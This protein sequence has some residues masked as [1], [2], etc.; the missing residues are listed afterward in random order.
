MSFAASSGAGGA[1]GGGATSLLAGVAGQLGGLTGVPGVG[2]LN[3]AARAMQLAQTTASLLGGKTPGGIADALNAVAGQKPKLTQMNRFVTLRSSLGPDVLLV[4]AMTAD[5]HVN[6]LGEI[7]LDLLSHQRDLKIDT[8]VGQPVSIAL[9]P[10]KPGLFGVLGDEDATRRYFHGHVVSFACVG[11]SGTV[12]RY[13]MTVVPWFWFL[14]RSTDCRIFQNQSAPD[15]L[16]SVF[17]EYGFNDFELNLKGQYKPLE[18]I[19]MYRESYYNFCARL[20]E[21]EGMLWTV[22]HEKDK[23]V[24]VIADNNEAFRPIPDLDTIPYYADSAASDLNGISQW[25]EAFSFRVGKITYRDFNHQTPSSPLL[26]VEVP[27]TLQ[28][29]NIHTTERYEYQSLYD[30]GDDGQRYAR[31]AM[32]AEEAQAHRFDGAASAPKMSTTSRF[33]LANHPSSA[34][35]NKEF[36]ILHVRH[37]AVNDYTRQEADQPYRNTFSCL[38]ADVPYR[39][40]RRTPKPYMHG[41]Q[42]AVVVGPEGEEIHTDGSSVKVHFF[43]D[44]RGKQDGTDSIWVRVS[45]PWAGGGWG[46]SAIPRIGQEVIVAF[47][48][49]DPDNPVIVG[50]VFNGEAKNPY[51]GSSGTTMGMRSQTHKGQG[52]NEMKFSDVAGSEEVFVHAQKDMNTVIKDNETRSIESGNRSITVH[53]GDEIKQVSLGNL[54]ETIAQTRSTTANVVNTEA[55]ASKAG[56]GMQSHQATD[57]IEH[58]VG[59]SVVTLTKDSIKL[60]HGASTVLI[61][62]N[63]IFIDG[64]VIHLNQGTTVTPEQALAIQWANQQALIAEGLASADPKIRDAAKQYAATLKARQMAQL[65]NAVY[66]PGTAP[67]G[68]KN[69]TNDPDALSKYGLKPKDFKIAGSNFGAQAYAPDPAVF[70]DSMKPTVAFKGTEQLLGEDMGNNLEQGRG[71][72]SP[73]YA[74]AVSM[75]KRIRDSGGAGDLD[76]TGHSLGGG[77]AAAASE[78]SGSP[79]TTFNAAGLNPATLPLYGAAP[80]AAAITNYRVDGDVLTGMQEGRLGPISDATAS[81]MPK[82]VGDQITIPGTS[83]TTIARH[84]MPQ[85]LGGM[86]SAA[87]G[88]ASTLTSLLGGN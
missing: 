67:P 7:H 5:E 51:H 10:Q 58:R 26:H 22:R 57:G 40:E 49:G 78:A 4:T 45:Q 12:T 70:G 54:T 14:T 38:P 9:N 47:N 86:D 74:Q 2:A 39:P 61:N 88:Q 19:V 37:E 48:E 33:K 50:R 42:A 30:H 63:G 32:E 53:K 41:T 29:P 15:I 77:L 44:R 66:S 27:T 16:A 46:G 21:Q 8:V 73:Y 6:Q 43:W 79:A 84:K 65:S 83:M 13:Q 23:H 17:R 76:L 81:L 75:G 56:P 11:N 18:Y 31:F 36:A 68:W 60:A 80:Q 28:N 82:A 72:E 3:Q 24:L 1:A 34:F 64:P 87:S 20:M 59:E 62:Q 55:I 85:V 35:N 25:N 52:F 71:V 69:I